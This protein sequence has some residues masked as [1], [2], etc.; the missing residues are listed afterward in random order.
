MS[1][2]IGILN[3]VKAIEFSSKFLASGM[4]HNVSGFDMLEKF[5]FTRKFEYLPSV[6]AGLSDVN[7]TVHC[8]DKQQTGTPHGV[9]WGSPSQDG[10]VMASTCTPVGHGNV[11]AG[12]EGVLPCNGLAKL[13]DLSPKFVGPCGVSGDVCQGNQTQVVRPCRRG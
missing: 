1:K 13:Q 2:A 7:A 9:V 8:V 10:K 6:V 5:Q 3:H 12:R 11:D 4:V